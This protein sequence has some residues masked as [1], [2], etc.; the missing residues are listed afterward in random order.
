MFYRSKSSQ[1]GESLELDFVFLHNKP[2][3]TCEVSYAKKSNVDSC[4]TRNQK[5]LIS[6]KK[7]LIAVIK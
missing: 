6:G 5:Q 1:K 2:N 7:A 3:V 4:E